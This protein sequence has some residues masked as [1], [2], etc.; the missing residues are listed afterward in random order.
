MVA[1][2]PTIPTPVQLPGQAVSGAIR[3]A[4]KATGANFEYLLATAQ[5][6]SGFD[7]RAAAK[8]S[9]ARGLFQ[10]I[11]QT[12]LGTMKQAGQSLGYGR[13][14]DAI[15]QTPSGRYEVGD[16]ALKREILHL[17]HDPGA[18]AAMAGA[19]TKSNAA[20]LARKLGRAPSE[21]ELYIAHFLG[22]GGAG[23]LIALAGDKPGARAADVF[24]GAARANRSIFYDK[25]GNARSL[26]GVVSEL[27]GRY[28]LARAASAPTAVATVTPPALASPATVPDTAA[29]TNA[30]AAASP[31]EPP[32]AAA[33]EPFF[34]SLFRVSGQ[35]GPVAPVVNALWRD[36][37]A[38]ANVPLPRAAPGLAK[39]TMAAA[40]ATATAVPPA[41]ASANAAAFD[42][43]RDLARN[44]RAI[45]RA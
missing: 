11:E 8:T 19:F 39:V 41:R 7:P 32:R 20:Y 38:A 1:A 25:S 34:D 31:H 45:F 35:R 42:L 30:F 12:W 36:L 10:F 24:A 18:N 44:V 17:R 16:P 33:A 15:T 22:A 43:F 2:A 4:A 13:Y 3:Q 27:T 40:P 26:A 14:A 9:S 6:E 23:K 28:Q 37:P 5:V 21:G 29:L